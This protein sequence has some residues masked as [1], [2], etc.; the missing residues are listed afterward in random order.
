MRDRPGSREEGGPQRLICIGARILCY[1]PALSLCRV[2]QQ[3]DKDYWKILLFSFSISFSFL[4][5]FPVD[6]YLFPTHLHFLSFIWVGYNAK[7]S[8][9]GH[10]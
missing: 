8:R 4:L 1:T 7:I 10:V 3:F 6:V 9:A 5:F 2:K